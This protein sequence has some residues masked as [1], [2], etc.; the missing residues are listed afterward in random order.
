MRSDSR[1]LS[2][3]QF[4]PPRCRSDGVNCLLRSYRL[5][6]ALLL[7]CEQVSV[8]SA[9]IVQDVRL[10]ASRDCGEPKRNSSEYFCSRLRG[11]NFDFREKYA[12]ISFK[13][14]VSYYSSGSKYGFP[15][16]LCSPPMPPDYCRTWMVC[17]VRLGYLTVP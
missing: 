6:D 15:F 9:G 5:F 1:I 7:R 14:F 16:F 3:I 17:Q 11:Y 2:P 12:Q 10:V 4:S 8:R 13:L